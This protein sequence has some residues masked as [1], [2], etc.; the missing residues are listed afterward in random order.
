[1]T[2]PGQ[3]YT[4]GTLAGNPFA[5][6]VDAY[7]YPIGGY[8]D[9]TNTDALFSFP[10]A[11]APDN[12]GNV[13]VADTLNNAIRRITRVGGD[14]MVVTIAGGGPTSSGSNNGINS[15]AQF[16]FP[17][18]VAVDAGGNLYVADMGNYTIRKIAPAGNNWMVTTIAGSPGQSGTNDG[19]GDLARFWSPTSVAV[20]GA[21]NVYVADCNAHTIRRLSPAGT[22]WIVQTIAGAFGQIGSADGTNGQARFHSPASIALDRAGRVYVSDWEN[23]TIRQITPVGPDYVVTTIAGKAGESGWVDGTGSAARF[24]NPLGGIGVDSTGTLYVTDNGMIRKIKPVGTN[25]VVTTIAGSPGAVGCVEGTGSAVRFY[26]PL[27]VAADNAGNLYVA[28]SNNNAIRQGVLA[29]P[30]LQ[31]ARQA[32][33]AVLSWPMSADGFTLETASSLTT[34]GIW[35]S[36]TNGVVVSGSSLVLTNGPM[37]Q[38]AFYRL[39]LRQ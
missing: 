28:D 35:T 24:W 18:G 38:N 13:F 15:E 14:W 30:T 16:S 25:W 12:A 21:T 32:G 4:F 9:G 36:L 19:P 8:T 5:I 20:D 6:G 1:M 22:N 2:L 11:V 34:G 10:Q 29:R 31:I 27:A 37:T 7:G 39:H 33:R 26:W 23:S 3:T 17:Y